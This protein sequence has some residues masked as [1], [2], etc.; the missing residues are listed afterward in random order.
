MLYIVFL[1]FNSNYKSKVNQLILDIKRLLELENIELIKELN[2]FD[3]LASKSINVPS[4]SKAIPFI[5]FIL[6]P[7]WQ[8]TTWQ[9]LSC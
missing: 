6:C 3:Q 7:I 2:P 4:L 9:K 5:S 1:Y 8:I